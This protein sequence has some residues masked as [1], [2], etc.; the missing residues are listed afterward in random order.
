MGISWGM[1][2]EGP[3]KNMLN[4]LFSSCDIRIRHAESKGGTNR[5]KIRQASGA[6]QRCSRRATPE[7]VLASTTLGRFLL[8]KS[9]DGS[10]SD[11]QTVIC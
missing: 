11:S 10:E 7:S 6:V 2:I 9:Q 4:T 1:E 3:S 8:T 5:T